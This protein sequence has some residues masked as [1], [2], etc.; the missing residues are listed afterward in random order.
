MM[1]YLAGISSIA[2]AVKVECLIT[3][4]CGHVT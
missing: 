3:A 4:Y 1:T 2:N